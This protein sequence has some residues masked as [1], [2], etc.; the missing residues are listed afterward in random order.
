MQSIKKFSEF[1]DENNR[2]EGDK[3]RIDDV[4]NKKIIV[5]KFMLNK[6]KYEGK[7]SYVT[8]QILIDDVPKVIFTGSQVISSQ[9][10]K[11]EKEM[12]F[13]ATIKK[14]DRYYTFT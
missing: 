11:Y 4:L 12:P 5:Q 1:A 2:F 14:I 3:I 8:I 10:D 9:C 7:G 6:S 13:M